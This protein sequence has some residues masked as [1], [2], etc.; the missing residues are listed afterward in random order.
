MLTQ[1]APKILILESQMII[2][3]D[4]SLQF[5]KLGYD[6]IGINTRSEEALKTIQNNR[7]DIVI[8]NIEMQGKADG[9]K[10]ARTILETYQIP[11]VFLSANT[12]KEIFKGV[13]DTKPYAFITKPFDK[14]GLKRGIETTLKRMAAEGLW[15]K[16]TQASSSI[17]SLFIQQ[18]DQFIK[19]EIDEILFIAANRNYCQLATHEKVY[20]LS[21]PLKTIEDQLPGSRFI[22]VHRSFLVNLHKI[23]TLHGHGEY[24]IIQN[25]K[26]PIS[27]RLRSYVLKNIRRVR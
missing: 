8:M 6:V 22:R 9:L 1:L 15:D 10:I 20:Q 14:K 7:P 2:A 4:V 11:V 21:V 24:L 19:I 26:I 3:A 17:N 5:S 18:K 25:H 23:N 13:I 27:R 12:D 16:E